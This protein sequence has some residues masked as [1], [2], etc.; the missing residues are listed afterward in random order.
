VRYEDAIEA[1]DV[2]GLTATWSVDLGFAAVDREVADLTEGAARELA[3]AAGLRLIERPIELT[4]PVRTWMT[5]GALDQ[6]IDLEE[7]YFPE[8]ADE[9]MGFVRRDYERSENTTL[10]THGRRLKYR[11][12]LEAEVAAAF[13]DVDV[14][15]TP[16][17][18]VTAFPAAGPMPTVINGRE[19]EPGMAVPF[20][21]LANLCHNPAISVPAG[22]TSEGLPVGLQI[23]ARRHHDDVVLRV[24]R[25]FE[26]TRPWP[27]FAPN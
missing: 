17:T 8:R 20:T 10:R 22:T 6:W 4:D 27:R 5:A 7:G 14:L 21:M 12:R 2:R 19:V 3:A 11:Q 26:Q 24:A 18:A 25:V 23:I 9:L 1:L 13:A 15:L 16:A